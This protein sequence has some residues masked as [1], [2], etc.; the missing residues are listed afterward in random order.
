[1]T[2]F[3]FGYESYSEN[4]SFAPRSYFVSYQST[5]SH[6]SPGVTHSPAGPCSW[7]KRVAKF[8]CMS[9]SNITR[10]ILKWCLVV[11]SVLQIYAGLY[12]MV[13]QMPDLAGSFAGFF[14]FLT[15]AMLLIAI[16]ADA[17][18]IV[19]LIQVFTISFVIMLSILIMV[20]LWF[21]L[22][23]E[24]LIGLYAASFFCFVLKSILIRE[25]LAISANLLSFEV[26]RCDI[27]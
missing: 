16:L 15:G 4:Q 1:M 13:D 25:Y 3:P 20:S 11:T 2:K 9:S 21:G 18:A 6:G 8:T 23:D 10:K 7:F 5:G 19:A 24:L 22:Q 26:V 14:I 12:L 27:I 17:L